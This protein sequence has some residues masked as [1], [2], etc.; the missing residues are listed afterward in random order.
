MFEKSLKSKVL[1]PKFKLRCPPKIFS[2]TKNIHVYKEEY[3][4]K[5]SK[6]PWI[7][8]ST[9]P[10]IFSLNRPKV[11]SM[12]LFTALQSRKMSTDLDCKLTNVI[13]HHMN[14]TSNHSSWLSR[15]QRPPQIQLE[16]KRTGA[17]LTWRMNT[18]EDGVFT[19]VFPNHHKDSCNLD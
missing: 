10:Y 13:W 3:A 8:P 6:K 2:K 5:W 4:K 17:V 19:N 16:G 14:E 11:Y 1:W 12:M 15:L 9:W 7:H 18:C